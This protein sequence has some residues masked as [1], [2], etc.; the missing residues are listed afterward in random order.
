MGTSRT[1]AELA[2]KF[3]RAA[4]VV[5][6]GNVDNVKAVSLF[7]KETT[8]ALAAPPTGGDL[9]FSNNKKRPI[10]VR[11]DLISG[12]VNAKAKVKAGGPMSWLE[13]GVKPHPT[14]PKSLGGTRRNRLDAVASIARG[15]STTF[16]NKRGVLAFAN[17]KFAAYA[18]NSGGLPAR[19]TWSKGVDI[20]EAR[21]AEIT[22][23]NTVRRLS[24]V[25]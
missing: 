8:L 7:L 19:G 17:G 25:F 18:R 16:G 23:L 10:T 5:T 14:A 13:S 2:G 1:A 11:Y 6:D 24:S 4:K 20:A 9:R 15:K 22:R 12:G 21:Q 3:D